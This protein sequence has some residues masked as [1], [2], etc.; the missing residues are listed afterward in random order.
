[1]CKDKPFIHLLKIPLGFYMF[2]V[3]TNTVLEIDKETYNI[4]HKCMNNECKCEM[5]YLKENQTDKIA[6]LI[7]RGFLSSG[8]LKEIVHPAYELMEY[9][10]NNK[11]TRITLQITQQCNLRCD[12]CIYS[13]NSYL[14]RSHTSKTM[15]LETA[16]KG[17]DFLIQHSKDVKEIN[18]G[19][20]GGEPLLDF[21]LV[22]K[23]IAYAEE[24]AEGKE[25]TFSIT[26][27]ATLLT[28]NIVKYLEEHKVSIMIS[29]DG[30]KEIHDKSRK[31]AASGCG[32]FDVI[33]KNVENIKNKF[34]EYFRK[35]FF[36]VVLNPEEDL[37]CVNEFFANY[38]TIKDSGIMATL[39][40]DS[41][42]NEKHIKTD[43]FK[44][45][46]NYEIFKIYLCALGK[47]SRNNI[48]KVFL[49]RYHDIA[50]LSTD[51]KPIKKVPDKGHHGGPCV[52]GEDRLF[53]N[54]DG[55]F[56]PCEK[57]SE[58]SEVMKIGHI[59]TGFDFEKA[60]NM[61][62]IGKITE[63]SCKNCWALL[64]CKLCAISADNIKEFSADLKQLA[65]KRQRSSVDELL[66]NFI[67]LRELGCDFG[68]I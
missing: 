47:I 53:L 55:Y 24:K 51:L 56:Y 66:K 6:S 39:V 26:T 35:I 50:K 64:H 2:D 30:P 10:L 1:M 19:F 40:N 36:S 20:Y 60:G 54:T 17:I 58:V 43:D 62:N 9:R 34:P 48:S 18:V 12:Y 59:D 68:T 22:K 52:P 41:L 44:I 3:N 23:C 27:N 42:M 37:C 31:F 5:C 29:L 15:S 7:R 14:Q 38:D 33:M 45:K 49:R 16:K 28:D 61:L 32:S 8:K 46:N 57:V 63:E 67:T 25:I 21:E 11:I 65:C 4:L 13:G